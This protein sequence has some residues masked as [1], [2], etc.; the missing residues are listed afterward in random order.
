MFFLSDRK[1]KAPLSRNKITRG[2]L[3]VAAKS[4]KAEP[5]QHVRPPVIGSSLI[6]CTVM[7]SVQTKS[8]VIK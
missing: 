3:N 6:E 4:S 5:E 2:K 1:E 7:E 8:S